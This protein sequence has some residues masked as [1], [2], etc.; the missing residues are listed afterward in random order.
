MSNFKAYLTNC[1]LDSLEI[2]LNINSHKIKILQFEERD[3]FQVNV[4]NETSTIVIDNVDKSELESVKI[5]VEKLVHLLKFITQK[6]VTFFAYSYP[7]DNMKSLWATVGISNSSRPIIQL[8]K[9]YVEEFIHQVWSKFNNEFERRKLDYIFEYLVQTSKPAICEQK[10][11]LCFLIFESLK[12][13]YAVEKMIPLNGG[14]FRKPDGKPFSF[15]ELLTMMLSEKGL[16]VP[17]KVLKDYRNEV[18]HSGYLSKND[19]EKFQMFNKSIKI[20]RDY[21]MKLLD[22]S[23]FYFEG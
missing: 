10:I 14:R 4:R 16:S 23:G 3:K 17:L 6:E 20:I 18:I 21:L 19:A 12:Y 15:E 5:L 13:T 1:I 11:V 8:H 22:Y 2:N 9:K 7:E